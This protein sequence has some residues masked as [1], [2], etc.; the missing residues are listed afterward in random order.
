M[1]NIHDSTILVL[2]SHLSQIMRFHGI[3]KYTV[4]QFDDPISLRK[5]V[6][7]EITCLDHEYNR[8]QECLEYILTSLNRNIYLKG[9]IKVEDS[10]RHYVREVLDKCVYV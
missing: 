6:E 5:I 8:A 4:R 9:N 10:L 2:G 3:S 7:I 1:S